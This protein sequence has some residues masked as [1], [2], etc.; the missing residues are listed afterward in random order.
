MA[1]CSKSTIIIYAAKQICFKEFC[2]ICLGE[3]LIGIPR[4]G[5]GRGSIVTVSSWW[6]KD[7][8]YCVTT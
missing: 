8:S 2:H 1:M 7:Q 6:S 5:N 4:E 3:I